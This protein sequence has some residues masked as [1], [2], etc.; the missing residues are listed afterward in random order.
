MSTYARDIELKKFAQ[1]NEAVDQNSQEVPPG[2]GA[3]QVIRDALKDPL[4]LILAAKFGTNADQATTTAWNQL[5]NDIIAK[6]NANPP[7]YTGTL[8]LAVPAGQIPVQWKVAED[9]GIVSYTNTTTKFT[10]SGSKGA[11]AAPATGDQAKPVAKPTTFNTGNAAKFDPIIQSLLKAMMGN[12]TDEE[13]ILAAF[14]NIKNQQEFVQFSNYFLSLHMPYQQYAYKD[15]IL[16]PSAWQKFKTE[17]PNRKTTNDS[18]LAQW[19][20]RELDTGEV[21]TLNYVLRANG[22][23]SQFSA[24]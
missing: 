18:S 5:K 19:I 23:T 14:V 20:G 7:V 4:E 21:K 1:V 6:V 17:A 10:A 2:G 9:T 24:L 11:S 13:A 3:G 8:N 15:E 12:R 16:E 22:I